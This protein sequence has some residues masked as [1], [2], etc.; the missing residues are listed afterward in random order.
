[1]RVSDFG[2]SFSHAVD[3]TMID[4]NPKSKKK[5]QFYEGIWVD[6][7]LHGYGRMILHNG[8]CYVG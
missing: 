6:D 8:D 2:I 4:G 1:M 3:E 5:V 7:K